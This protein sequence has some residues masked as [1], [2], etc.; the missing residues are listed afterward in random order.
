MEVEKTRLWRKNNWHTQKQKNNKKIDIS[1]DLSYHNAHS[2]PYVPSSTS[3]K[4]PFTSSENKR[5]SEKG[6]SGLKS[7][8]ETMAR[9]KNNKRTKL[10]FRTIKMYIWSLVWG[11]S[12]FL[13]PGKTPQ[14]CVRFAT[15]SNTRNVEILR[16]DSYALSPLHVESWAFKWRLCDTRRGRYRGEKFSRIAWN[17]LMGPSL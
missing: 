13:Y 8:T 17:F 14:I 2:S 5:D 11:R 7:L 4:R 15:L 16:R 6:H 9:G 12:W 3:G 10:V 1:E